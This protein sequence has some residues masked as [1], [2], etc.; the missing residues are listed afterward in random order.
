MAGVRGTHLSPT[1]RHKLTVE[2][3][4]HYHANQSS[5][6][7]GSQIAFGQNEQKGWAKDIAPALLVGAM[8]NAGELP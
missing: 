7:P 2:S 6:Q 5:D 1:V 4:S 3:I 8:R